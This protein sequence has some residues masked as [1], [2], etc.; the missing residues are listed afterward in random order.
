MGL[1]SA[2]V[3]DVRRMGY[4][5]WLND[6]VY[7]TGI[8][9]VGTDEAITNRYPLLSQPAAQLAVANQGT[10]QTQLQDAT[11]YRAAFATRRP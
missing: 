10:L 11:M 5:H 8:D 1:T 7:Y 9:D 6:Q 3:A 2:D 4:Q